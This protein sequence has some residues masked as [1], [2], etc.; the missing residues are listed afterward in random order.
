MSVGDVE[1][2]GAHCQMPFCHQLD[3]LPFRCESCK[4]TFCLD[5]RTETAHKCT[6]AGAWARAKAGL[7]TSPSKLP[8]KPT[9]LNHESQCAK[10]DCKTLID[11]SLVQGSHC[12]TCNRRYCMK[13]RMPEDHACKDLTP[14]GARPISTLQQQREKGLAALEKLKAWSL[15]KK[16]TEVP[17]SSSSKVTRTTTNTST[18]SKTSRFSIRSK[19]STSS[20]IAEHNRLKQVAKGDAAKVPPERRIYVHVTAAKESTSAKIPHGEFF[21]DSK[22]SVGKVLDAAAKS[23][24]VQNVNNRVVGEEQKLRVFLIKEDKKKGKML[25]FAHTLEQEGVETGDELVLLRGAGPPVPDL[26]QL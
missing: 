19:S 4:G 1:A 23:L 13:H 17:S 26:I 2:I 8:P 20:A 16:Q 14:I 22:W 7:D 15:N 3:F 25:E 21:Y 12:T 18:E 6:N 10:P 11:T 5:H 24:Q 9:I